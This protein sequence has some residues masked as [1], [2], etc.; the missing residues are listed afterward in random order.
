MTDEPNG[1]GLGDLFSF[2]DDDALT[3]PR[4]IPSKRHPEG[5]VYTIPAP[6][7]ETGM[8]LTAL[9][10]VA[11]KQERG[12]KITEADAAKLVMNDDEEREFAVQVMGDTYHEMVADGVSWPRIQKIVQYA[13]IYFAMGQD[14][15]EKAAREGIL[16]GGKARIPTNRAARRAQARQRTSRTR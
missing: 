1:T 2:L 15:A 9:A 13:Y 3:I 5:K 11:A 4:P 12:L 16:N 14:V 7:A 6:D 8:R 10:D